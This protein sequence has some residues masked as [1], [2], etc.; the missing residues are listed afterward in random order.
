MQKE[1][2]HPDFGEIVLQK[3][4]TNKNI[5]ISIRTFNTVKKV[6]VSIPWYVSYKNGLQ[7]VEKNTDWIQKNL[8]KVSKYIYLPLDKKELEE[9]RKKAR[10]ILEKKLDNLANRYYFSYNKLK[11]K[12]NR[13]NWGSCSVQENINL[14][15]RLIY[16]P[17]DLM[18]YIIL[19]ELVH[20]H[21]MNHSSSFHKELNSILEKHTG[22]KNFEKKA[23][24]RM[25]SYK[26]S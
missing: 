18:D 20:L 3:K 23:I 5:R 9:I 6:Y 15:I 11:I 1:V 2:V 7:A 8:S 24:K 22:D 25:H 4:R 19:H 17:E 14:N 12:N 26:I 16:L 10:I 13:S 21:H